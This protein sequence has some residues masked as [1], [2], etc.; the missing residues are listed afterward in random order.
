[1]IK[2]L[3]IKAM[4]GFILVSQE[5]T[6][7]FGKISKPI[8][9]IYSE[10]TFTYLHFFFVGSFALSASIFLSVYYFFSSRVLCSL[11]CFYLSLA[12]IF[13]WYLTV[14]VS[15]FTLLFSF[16]IKFCLNSWIHLWYMSI[17]ALLLIFLTR[18]L[19]NLFTFHISF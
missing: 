9:Y 4:C 7:H 5:F 15:Y 6:T 17:P 2:W 3:F 8:K 19:Y 18:S 16:L 11:L 13:F 1:M 14:A 10:S 12:F